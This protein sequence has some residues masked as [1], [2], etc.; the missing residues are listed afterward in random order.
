S[1]A[2]GSFI[3]LSIPSSGGVAPSEAR[4]RGGLPPVQNSKWGVQKPSLLRRGVRRGGSLFPFSDMNQNM[5][6]HPVEGEA[7]GERILQRLQLPEQGDATMVE[8]AHRRRR[9]GKAHTPHRNDPE[10]PFPEQAQQ[11][12]DRVEPGDGRCP[13]A[14]VDRTPA[15]PK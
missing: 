1:Y 8:A 12:R 4:R 9:G 15:A 6:P 2:I 10:S 5:I 11:R 3:R 14:D 13:F 7:G